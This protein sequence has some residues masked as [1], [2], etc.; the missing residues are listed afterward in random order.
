MQKILFAINHQ[1]TEDSIKVHLQD[2]F[3]VV[4]AVTYK[5][6][7]IEQLKTTG[8]DTLLIRDTLA[9]STALETL[10]KRVRVEYPNVR[11]VVICSERPKRDPFLQTLVSMGI[12]DIINSDHPTLT[13]IVSYIR[14]PRTYRDAAQY[15]IG[16]P[17]VPGGSTVPTVPSAPVTAQQPKEPAK[18]SSNKIFG[19]LGE[20]KKGFSVLK[21]SMPGDK[22]QPKEEK[23]DVVDVSATPQVNFDLLRESI[24]ESEARKA[25]SDLDNLIKEAVEK[26][27]AGLLLENASLQK[28][29]DEAQTEAAVAEAHATSVM[30]ELNSLRAEKDTLTI[31]LTDTRRDM[32]QVIDMYEAQLKALHDPTNT[33]EWYSEQSALW[34]SQKSSLMK[35]LDEKSREAS[36]LAYKCEALIKQTQDSSS[37]IADLKEQV[38]RAQDMQLDE[39]GS[40]ELIG[41]LRA[42]T[43]EAKSEALQMEAEIK[44]LR[45]ELSYARAGGVDFSLPV[46]D[47]PLLP[48]DATYAVS[49][50]AP[51]TILMI[52]SKHGVGTTTVA[53][54]FAASLAGRGLKTLLVEVNGNYPLCNQFF[55]FTH[56]PFGIDEAI[57][58]VAAGDLEGIDKA[59]IRPHG[60]R[61]A[62][63]SLRKLYKK[64]PAGLHFMLFSNESLVN[65][66]FAKNLLVTEATVYTMLSY[67]TKRQQYSHVVL[68]VQCDD[69]QMLSSIL[70][71]GYQIDKLCIVMTQDPHAVATAGVQITNL[72]RAHASSLI[73]G[74]EFI[75]NRYNSSAPIQ[76]KKIEQMLH[77]G[78]AQITR[79]T[80][81]TTGYYAAA[82]AGLPYL[83]NKGHNWMEYDALRSKICPE[84]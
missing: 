58:A 31:T 11:I 68:D 12:Y 13:D 50:G 18:V 77:L 19:F 39:R 51:Q 7:V 61:P 67:L 81:D 78:A 1:K 66:S 83:L 29:V 33:P 27:T 48:D 60:L 32:Q 46:V 21:S 69:E 52:G 62:Q 53:M 47:V 35:E 45:D 84:T 41:R 4:G 80:E 44:K 75:I 54:N 42:E 20:V 8:A 57:N 76:Q 64:M 24:K 23:S 65:H 71:S 28:K 36:E 26:Q 15:G 22:S 2:D 6:A 30:E 82:S 34:E 73:A 70:N 63:G 9:G 3:L 59:I 17:E 74:G 37:I 25:Q 79:I 43:S 55:E 56:I 72:S 38:Q 16:L 14:S 49:S 40:D 10:L 5:E